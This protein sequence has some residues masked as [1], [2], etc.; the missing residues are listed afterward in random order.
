MDKYG[1]H[2][3][4]TGL[5]TDDD[6]SHYADLK[7]TG[8]RS[9]ARGTAI[10]C[11]LED[12]ED[13]CWFRRSDQPEPVV[14]EGES[15]KRALTYKY[16]SLS[17]LATCSAG[18][19]NTSALL[20]KFLVFFVFGSWSL[21][22]SNRSCCKMFYSIVYRYSVLTSGLSSWGGNIGRWDKGAIDK[23]IRK[24]E[25]VVGRTQDSFDN[26]TGRTNDTN[27]TT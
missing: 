24:P 1:D 15:M 8:S 19:Q 16:I 11:M 5:I 12:K 20:K 21:L 10:N 9:A 27:W 13:D 18:K 23:I 22:T 17:F 4:L 6:D 25:G 7:S 2:T 14:I 26:A 3:V